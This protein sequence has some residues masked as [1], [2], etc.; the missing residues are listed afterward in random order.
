MNWVSIGAGNGLTPVPR[1]AITRTNAD[2]LSIGS[3]GT[4]FSEIQMTSLMLLLRHCDVIQNNGID[5]N[6][7]IPLV[8]KFKSLININEWNAH[9]QEKQFTTIIDF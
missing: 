5:N 2:L 7:A 3:L 9:V 1:Q 4:N 6:A 8:E